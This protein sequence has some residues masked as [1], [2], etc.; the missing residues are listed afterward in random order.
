MEVLRLSGHW[1]ASG[2]AV[3]TTKLLF[4]RLLEHSLQ[5]RLTTGGGAIRPKVQLIS[6]TEGDQG[7]GG[8][9]WGGGGG[10]RIGKYIRVVAV[11]FLLCLVFLRCLYLFALIFGHVCNYSSGGLSLL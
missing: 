4:G 3:R 9:R 5:V 1:A 10:V 8:T 2:P 6:I 11:I 7:C